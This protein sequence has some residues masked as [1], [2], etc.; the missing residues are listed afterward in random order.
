MTPKQAPLPPPRPAPSDLYCWLYAAYPLTKGGE[1]PFPTIATNLNVSPETVRQWLRSDGTEALTKTQR[2]YLHRRAILRGRG[3]YLWPLIDADTAYTLDRTLAYAEHC[4]SLV[5]NPSRMPAT[6]LADKTLTAH[7]VALMHY[8]RAHVYGIAS[9]RTDKHYARL[10]SHGNIIDTVS[11]ANK[12]AATIAK[13]CTLKT[14]RETH[15][16]TPEEFVPTGRTSTWRSTTSQ[17][18]TTIHP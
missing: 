10:A 15:C 13:I 4:L 14:H 17:H 16:T 6:W 3:T 2:T 8:P 9:G 5:D 18:Q 1:L 12:H 7:W 11:V